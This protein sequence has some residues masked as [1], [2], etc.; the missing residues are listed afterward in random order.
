MRRPPTGFADKVFGV[1]VSIRPRPCYHWNQ[2]DGLPR[3]AVVVGSG[4]NGLAAAIVLAR[5]G[6]PVEVREAHAVLGGAARSAELTLPGF[7][8]DLGS[9]VHPLAVSSPFFS[10]LSLDRYGLR[11][12]TPP[13]ALAHPFED[14]SAVTVERGVEETASQLG[15]DAQ[16]YRRLFRPLARNWGMLREDLLRPVRWPAHPWATA[17]FGMRA[18]WPAQRLARR[19]F[20]GARARALLAGLA[21]HSILPLSSPL[22]S[23]VALMLGA[24][25]HG[26]GWPVPQGGAAQITA[27]LAKC[28]ETSGGSVVTDTE[29]RKIEELDSYRPALLDITPRQL[30]A[31]GGE[32]LAPGYRAALKRYR[33]GPGVFKM[34][35]ALS[36]PAPWKARECL[37]AG[38]V[39][40]GSSLEEIAESESDVWHGKVSSRPFVLLSQP[41]LFDPSRAPKNKHILWGYCHVPHGWQGSA[42]DVIEAQI[43]RY[44]PGFRDC[45]L[46]R[47]AMGPAQMEAWNPNLVGG[48][49]NGGAFSGLQLFFRPTRRLYSTSLAGVYL[50]S[51]ST[52]PGGG[53][54]GMCGYWAARRA[55][56]EQQSDS[57]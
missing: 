29:V 32:R 19:G 37:R 2:G 9:A 54:H 39:H 43:E 41:T 10:R 3:R 42:V 51:S 17:R 34:D 20:R 48:D 22:S 18:V 13:A 47:S 11:W 8:H 44:A 46:A 38:T 53:V 56:D 50:C 25:A 45:I 23:A 21:A 14:G 26:P 1:L 12:I 55:L 31:M 5:A 30:L 40:L 6:M 52:P 28:L 36:E 57:K 24:A 7:L 15:A 35:W 27:A 16:A 49:I 4:P 33:Y